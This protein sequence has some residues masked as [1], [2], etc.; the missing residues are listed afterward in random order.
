MAGRSEVL[1]DVSQRISLVRHYCFLCAVHD[2]TARLKNG[3]VDPTLAKVRQQPHEA[4]LGDQ[5]VEDGNRPAITVQE[6]HLSQRPRQPILF[7]RLPEGL[8]RTWPE[9]V[10]ERQGQFL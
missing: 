5:G 6:L 4:R 3:P 7:T 1:P 9:A 8:A 2:L 10:N